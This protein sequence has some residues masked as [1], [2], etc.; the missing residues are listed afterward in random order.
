MSLFGR[1]VTIVFLSILTL[2]AVVPPLDPGG[3]C[4]AKQR[5][6]WPGYVAMAC[7]TDNCSPSHA[8]EYIMVIVG[9]ESWFSC[10]CGGLLA[11]CA[12]A[13]MSSNGEKIVMCVQTSCPV[14]M[15][16]EPQ[17]ATSVWQPI[18]DCVYPDI[19]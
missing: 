17:T 6:A 19:M 15:T 9:T 1:L 18:C 8:C 14:L 3:V 10:A 16:C 2:A 5:E 13:W 11:P 12:G 4:V 7:P